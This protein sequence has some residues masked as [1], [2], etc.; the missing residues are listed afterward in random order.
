MVEFETSVLLFIYLDSK[1]ENLNHLIIYK[2]R[3]DEA[4]L[5]TNT[6]ISIFEYKIF[7]TT[8]LYKYFINKLVCC[9]DRVKSSDNTDHKLVK[10]LPHF[11]TVLLSPTT[12]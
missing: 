2:K 4:H 11:V 8:N 12:A 6:Y 5:H 1:S 3:I 9:P 7:K 10:N